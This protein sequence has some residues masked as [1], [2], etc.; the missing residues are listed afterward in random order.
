MLWKYFMTW[1]KKLKNLMIIKSLNYTYNKVILL[2]ECRESTES[3]NPE[4]IKRKNERIIP[5]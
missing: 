1:M 4:V 3:K 2:F 5:L